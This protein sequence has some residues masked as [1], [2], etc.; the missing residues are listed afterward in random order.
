MFNSCSGLPSMLHVRLVMRCCFLCLLLEFHFCN[1]MAAEGMMAE[2][3]NDDIMADTK[4]QDFDL[5]L[6][7]RPYVALKMVVSSYT[8]ARAIELLSYSLIGN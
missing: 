5:K 1:M 7:P 3:G 4:G 6:V 8:K 2:R